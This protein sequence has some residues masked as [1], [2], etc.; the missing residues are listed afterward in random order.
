MFKYIFKSGSVWYRRG[1]YGL[2]WAIV[3]FSIIIT[4]PQ[5]SYGRPW[6]QILQQGATAIQLSNLSDQQEVNFGQQIN[7]ELVKS[8]K[9]NLSQNQAINQ[10]VKEIGRRLVPYSSRPN[11]PYTFQV[12]NDKTVNAFATMGGYVYIH[13]GLIKIASNEAELASVIGHEMGHIAARHAIKQM[14]NA[15]LTQGLLG[16]AGLDQRTLVQLGVQLVYSLPH[17]RQDELEADQMGLQTIEQAGYAPSAMVSFMKKL[18][19]QGGSTPAFL[20]S[21]PATSYRVEQLQAAIDPQTANVGKG[22][23]SQAYQNRIRSIL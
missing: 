20:S 9:I 15:A 2:L 4:S 14:R 1:L 11:I 5:A 19:R 10:Y 22:L 23:D 16:V 17:S 3:A 13:T 21:H 18:M 7:Q 12:V 8:R 6:W